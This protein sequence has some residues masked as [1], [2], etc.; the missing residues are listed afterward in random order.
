MA[1][2]A[3]AASIDDLRHLARR[4]LPRAVFDFI[5]GGSGDETTLRANRDAFADWEF[6]PRVAID[7]ALRSTEISLLGRPARLPLVVAPTGLAGLFWPGGEIAVAQAAA[8]AGIPFC[9][10]TNSVASLEEVAAAVPA[11]R[12]F[13]LYPMRDREF[14]AALVTRAWQAGYGTLCLTLDLPVQGRRN[15]DIRNAFTVPFRPRLTNVLDLALHPGFLLDLARSP[16]RFG[17][18]AALAPGRAVTVAQ[19]VAT[20]FEP[21]T[22]WD[23]VAAL[24]GSWPGRF[25]VKGVLHPDDA[26]RCV[27]AG[28]D[29]VIVSNHGGRQLDGVPAAIRALP[30]VV[31]AVADEVEV[32]LDGGVRRGDDVLKALAL[33]ARACMIGRAVLWGL[34]AKG[35]LG[36]A[37][38]LSILAEEIDTGMALIGSRS[39]SSLDEAMLRRAAERPRAPSQAG[40]R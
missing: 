19:H 9:L 6:L 16:V 3:R 12:W 34:S 8:A 7:V 30:I 37:R 15:R 2:L 1:D 10:S 35:R 17:N 33:G 31:D 32:L 38:A 5:D 25:V 28:A 4:R 23:D 21:S 36:V 14:S 26:R 22:T 27:D 11:E 39:V 40:V 13:Q 24:R 20:L 29:A 18:F